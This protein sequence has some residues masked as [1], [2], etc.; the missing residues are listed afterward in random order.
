MSVDSGE[1]FCSI[2]YSTDIIKES[3]SSNHGKIHLKIGNTL[4]MYVTGLRKLSMCVHTN[5]SVTVPR[6]IAN[7]IKQ[8]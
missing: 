5:N 7:D 3:V 2:N 8:F 6:D 1:Y 4:Y